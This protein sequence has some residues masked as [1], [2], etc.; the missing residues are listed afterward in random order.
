MVSFIQH[1]SLHLEYR[2]YR[3][4]LIS[5]S[6]TFL[7]AGILYTGGNSVINI[8]E[9]KNIKKEN[10][11]IERNI[12]SSS[13]EVKSLK[14][15]LTKDEIFITYSDDKDK[16]TKEKI[17]KYYENE[18][19]YQYLHESPETIKYE[20]ILVE[21]NIVRLIGQATS[22]EE[23]NKYIEVLKNDK[24]FT[25]I[26]IRGLDYIKFGDK[27]RF[28]IIGYKTKASLEDKKYIDKTYDKEGK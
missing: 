13:K 16:L 10:I 9:T 11:E 25:E 17:P 15:E 18:K 12:S 14:S 22:Y 6:Y 5:I 19:L 28:R 26:E 23:I 3:K 1:G 27:V 8:I 2:R 21:E 20:S 7:I 24:V 4:A